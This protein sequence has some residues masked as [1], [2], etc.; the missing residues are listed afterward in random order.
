MFTLSAEKR[1]IYEPTILH[2][3]VDRVAL[4]FLIH[5]NI[6]IGAIACVRAC[7]RLHSH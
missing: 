6:L 7:V 5:S 3:N 4:Q 2:I 1:V